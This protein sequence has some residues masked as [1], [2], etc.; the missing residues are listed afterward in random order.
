MIG[1]LAI[2]L[3]AVLMIALIALAWRNR[4][5]LVALSHIPGIFAGVFVRERMVVDGD[6]AVA[7]GKSSDAGSLHANGQLNIRL[8]E[9]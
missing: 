3:N 4:R 7:N 2:S 6:A 9:R 8:C 1:G 5:R